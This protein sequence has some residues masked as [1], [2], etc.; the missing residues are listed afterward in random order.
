MRYPQA[1][2][3]LQLRRNISGVLPNLVDFR[4]V[5]KV[6]PSLRPNGDMIVNSNRENM[7]M[8]SQTDEPTFQSCEFDKFDRFR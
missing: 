6:F 1:L 5:R 3:W 4:E 8:I 2:G 7:S